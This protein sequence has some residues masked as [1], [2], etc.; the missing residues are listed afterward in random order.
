MLLSAV[1]MSRTCLWY[2][3]SNDKHWPEDVLSVIE[4]SP[5]EFIGKTT[6][7]FHLGYIVCV[8]GL[9]LLV[10]F[11]NWCG[12]RGAF[13]K[14]L[15]ALQTRVLKFSYLNT[16]DIFHCMWKIFCM[17]FQSVPLK[18]HTKYHTHTLNDTI[19]T[20]C[21]TF[22]SSQ[23]WELIIVFEMSPHSLASTVLHMSSI[24]LAPNGFQ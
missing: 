17:E 6:D 19:Y 5:W 24:V 22:N 10:M 4:T 11:L 1:W 16:M 9:T 14:R 7:L 21:W 23:I 18:F 20:Y 12:T 8:G 2:T 15:Q 13:Q 3:R